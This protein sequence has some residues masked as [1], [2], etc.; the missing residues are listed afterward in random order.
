MSSFEHA[1][2]AV[3]SHSFPGL[4]SIFICQCVILFSSVAT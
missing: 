4:M 1:G 2:T 3:L